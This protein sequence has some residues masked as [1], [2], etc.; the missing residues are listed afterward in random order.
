MLD[1]DSYIEDL[2]SVVNLDCGT[3]NKEGVNKVASFIQSKFKGLGFS[4]KSIDVGDEVAN[5]LIGTNCESETYDVIFSG[6]MDTVF[7]DGT[8]E[9]IPLR[10]D[11]NTIYGAGVQDMKSGIINTLYA[12]QSIGK[13][14]LSKLKIA[15]VFSPDEEI[16]SRFSREFLKKFVKG[17][18]LAIV[19]ESSP[20]LDVATKARKSI[21]SFSINIK[22]KAG[23]SSRPKEGASSIKALGGIITEL[24]K[25]E[26]HDKGVSVNIGMVSGGIGQNTIADNVDIVFEMRHLKLADYNESKLQYDSIINATYEDGIS[27]VSTVKSFKPPMEVVGDSEYYQNLIL[28]C[29]KELGI[30]MGYVTAAGG[31]D[32]NYIAS[33]GV[34]VIDSIG[35][36]GKG[37]HTQHEYIEF[38]ETLKRVELL[39]KI[40]IKLI[41]KDQ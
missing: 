23:H 36:V 14:E 4:F 12:M 5:L 8:S 33:V 31:S 41:E 20:S 2:K 35:A 10:I 21:A 34:P 13:D 24:Y 11:G 22:G 39:E 6:H 32:G 37:A 38:E 19:V 25:I 15:I 27:V 3:F 17:S 40:I 9:K 29:A 26:D 30:E 16:S 18:K 1:K 7:P 28:E